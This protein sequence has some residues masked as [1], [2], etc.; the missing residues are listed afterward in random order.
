MYEW[1]YDEK[2]KRTGIQKYFHENGKLMIEGEWNQGKEKG[3]IKEYDINGNLIS[4]KTFENGKLDEKSIKI[5]NQVQ[6]QKNSV[7]SDSS[8]INNNKTPEENN[9]TK[10]GLYSGSGYNITYTKDKKPEREGIWDNGILKEG[11]RYYYNKEGK[12]QKTCIYKN[13]NIVNTIFENQ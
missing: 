6:M 9:D 13:G 1:K 2:G 4:E 12:L 7:K 8:I 5:Y 10:L 3:A 11:K